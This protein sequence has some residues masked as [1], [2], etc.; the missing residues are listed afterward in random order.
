LVSFRIYRLPSPCWIVWSCLQVKKISKKNPPKALVDWLRENQGLDQSYGA[1]LGTPAHAA[2]KQQLIR[3]QGYLCAYTG[4]GI[5]EDTCHVEHLK[6]Q[7]R[8]EG[9]EDVEYHNVL[10]CFP[11]DGGD[12][13]HG[14]GAPVKAGWWEEE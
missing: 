4:R 8:C 5:T 3:E 6:P 11:A 10:A 14:Y 1:L 2:L 13:S 9:R 12:V 7:N